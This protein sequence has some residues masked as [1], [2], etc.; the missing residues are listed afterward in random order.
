MA[1]DELYIYWPTDFRPRIIQNAVKRECDEFRVRS[2]GRSKDF[3]I[4]VKRK[5][6]IAI[7]S[8]AEIIEKINYK[9]YKKG[10]KN[11]T[12]KESFVLV[13]FDKKLNLKP[14]KKPRIGALDIFG[15]KETKLFLEKALNKKVSYQRVVKV[16]DLI[17]LMQRGQVVGI[18]LSKSHLEKIK[19]L[20]KRK[21][22]KMDTGFFMSRATIGINKEI[23]N[24][25]K[26]D[27]CIYAL[28]NKS[29]ALMGVEQ[30][31]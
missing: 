4:K 7:I 23:I 6:P 8:F 12:D 31:L 9:M 11:N 16:E 26:I 25:Q 21:L 27:R 1:A 20:T 10:V 24:Y 30:W 22:V 3:Y 15:R 28:S 19:S 2:F 18:F 13:S 29:N 17:S 14:L 5:H